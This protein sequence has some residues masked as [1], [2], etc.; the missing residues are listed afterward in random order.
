MA[1]YKL[2]INNGASSAS[3]ISAIRKYDSSLSV[4][5]IKRR[6]EQGED[7]AG[8]AAL[9]GDVLDELNGVDRKALF[10]ALM[11]SIEEHGGEVGI[12]C[13]GALIG[14]ERYEN[15][16]ARLSEVLQETRIDMD[17]ESEE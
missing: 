6:I 5:E 2:K 12:Y 10:D 13:E 7:V 3:I 15:E 9:G 4:S 11:S 1:T 8:F 17:R 16:M 14:R